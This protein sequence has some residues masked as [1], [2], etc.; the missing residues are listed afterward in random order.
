MAGGMK[1]YST[2]KVAE[3]LQ[4][5]PGLIR[6]IV[7]AGILEPRR[8]QGNRYRF[9][10]QD[11]IVLRTAK[12]LIKGGVKR[13]RV[14]SALAGLKAQMPPG[15]PLTALRVSG[16][17]GAVVLHEEDQ[18]YTPATGQIHF[19]F[20]VADLA[21]EVAPLA[22]EA[23]EE[24]ALGRTLSANDWYDL[25]MDLEAVSP[26]DAPAAYLRALTL[27]PTHV[28]AHVQLGRL[29]QA[30]GEMVSAEEH[31]LLALRVEPQHALAAL[32]LGTLLEDTGRIQ[33]AI[34][35][36]KQARRLADAQYH[37]ARLYE[38]AGAH[39]EALRHFKAY[40]RLSA[41]GGTGP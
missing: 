2:R 1:G 11:I 26:A 7:R 31:Y 12:E 5:P 21:G 18:L 33:Q 3:T 10:F 30:A 17:G 32:S 24:A 22:R 41:A 9:S 39:A 13:A 16:I 4:L 8:A 19:N 14:Y 34:R 23:A 15:R 37:L 27:D 40:R 38:L 36:Y 25:G 6:E 29:L 28:E 20:S 35:A